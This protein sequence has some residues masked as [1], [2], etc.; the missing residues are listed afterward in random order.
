MSFVN[1]LIKSTFKLH[2]LNLNTESTKILAESLS[3]IDEQKHED[4]LEKIIDE[5]TKK[6]LDGSS[7]LTKIDIENVLKEFNRNDQNPNEKE[8]IF[9]IIDAFDVPKSIY[10]EVTKKLI[11]LSNDQ[12]S[13]KSVNHRTLLADSRAKID[14]FSQRFKLIHQRT[15]RHE[16]FSPCVVSSNNFG[17]KK[18]QLKPI[19]FL[20]SNINH[21]EDIIVLGMISQLK[22]NKFFIEDPT[23]HL[24]LNLTD[25]KYHSGIYTE[26][27]FVLAEGNLV[28]G[29]F[30]VKA[31]GFPPAEFEST[32]R[33]YFGNINYFGGPNEISCKSSIALSQAQL[34][35][36]SMIVFL[37]DVWLDS[38]KVFEKLQTLFVGYSDCP[39]YAFV[40]CGNFLSDLK[41][42]LR[43]NEL[44]EGFKRLADLITQFEAI[45]DNSNFIFIAGPQDPGVVRVYP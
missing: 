2:G 27:C 39:P 21:V 36:D 8:E 29:I 41:Y 18:F 43:C 31:L 19:E 7:C 23:G 40:F 20:L 14:I 34:S 37:S 17:K 25:A 38:A 3:K 12:R 6:N 26:G 32:S 15:M 9:H 22:E 4:T 16:L 45:K 33:A 44:I 30:E 10:C 1:Q 35:V 24:P 42:G 5:L 11:K 13:N 28:D